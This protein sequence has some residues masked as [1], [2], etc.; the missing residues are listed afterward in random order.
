MITTI[1][2]TITRYGRILPT[3]NGC[4]LARDSPPHYLLNGDTTNIALY[5]SDNLVNWTL[6]NSSF[7][8][9]RPGWEWDT[10]EASTPPLRLESGDYI[11][12]YAGCNVSWWDLAA[13]CTGGNTTGQYV[14]P[15]HTHARA[16][17]HTL[18]LP[19]PP[20][21]PPP[22]HHQ[23]HFTMCHAH[24]TTPTWHPHTPTITWFIVAK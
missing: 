20:P 14:L 3:R 6:A 21:P 4:L 9:H 2:T 22:P 8:S 13:V 11:H 15:P 24:L 17:A 19:L 10:L 1:T 5:T 23:V 7:Y 16:R 12:F 18:P